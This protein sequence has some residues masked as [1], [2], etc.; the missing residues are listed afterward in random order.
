MS[1]KSKVSSKVVARMLCAA[2]CMYAPFVVAG[3]GYINIDSMPRG[4]NV[5]KLVMRSTNCLGLTPYSIEHETG[6]NRTEKVLVKKFGYKSETLIL[7]DSS[8]DIVINLKKDRLF[9]SPSEHKDPVVAALQ[10][11]VNRVLGLL[12]YERNDY[13]FDINGAIGVNRFDNKIALNIPLFIN[14]DNELNKLKKASRT[15][16][17]DEKQKRVL[18]ILYEQGVYRFLESLSNAIKT[19]NIKIDV[20]SIKIGYPATLQVLDFEDV[21][22]TGQAYSHSSYSTSSSGVTTRTDYYSVYKY[23]VDR[24]VVKDTKSYIYYYFDLDMSEQKRKAGLHE[25]NLV[26]FTNNNR[27]HELQQILNSPRTR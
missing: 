26:I 14:T 16:N 5:C 4:A 18:K 19:N 24:T 7:D 11:E 3:S 22:L 9:Y 27:N 23:S 13:A 17:K 20:L 1:D 21:E 10:G 12:I 15:N 8:K 6:N 2:L 25:E